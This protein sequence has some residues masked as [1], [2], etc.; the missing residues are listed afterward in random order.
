VDVD[1]LHSAIFFGAGLLFVLGSGLAIVLA[2][3]SASWP[4]TSGTI[5]RSEIVESRTRRNVRLYESRIEYS[6]AVHGKAYRSD[7][8]CSG[9]MLHTRGRAEERC[10]KYPAGSPVRVFYKP[11]DPSR[12]CLEA[13]AE[14][15]NLMLAIGCGILLLAGCVRAGILHFD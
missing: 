15:S 3:R 1:Q 7:R 10:A 14:T 11:S 2:R 8:V 9:A 5:T 4:V 12:A 13:T 6:Y